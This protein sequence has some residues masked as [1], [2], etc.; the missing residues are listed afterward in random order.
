M[1]NTQFLEILK[2]SFITYLSTSARSNKKLEILHGAISKDLHERLQDHKYSIY[3][4][5]HETGKERKI[6]GRYIDKAVDITITEDNKPIAGIAVKYVMSNYSQNSNNYF[7]NMLGET[8]N[9][10]SAKIP[11]FQIFVIPD[12]IPYFDKYGAISK[13]ENINEHNLKKYIKM[14]ND[15]TNDFLHTPNKTLIFIVHIKDNNPITAVSCK[16]EYT[17]YYLHNDFAMTVSALNFDFGN[18]I[19]YNDYDKFIQKVVYAI[20]SV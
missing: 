11:Y 9:I 17:E 18:T 12:K 16:Q 3:S 4:L 6:I 5:G 2:Q 13:W 1:D 20:K 7:E 10:R 14:S 8:A 19:I 15:N